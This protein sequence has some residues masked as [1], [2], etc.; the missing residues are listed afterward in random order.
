MDRLRGDGHDI[1]Y[2]AELAAGASDDTVL[3]RAN[4]EGALLVTADKDFGE[5]VHRQRRVSGGVLLVRLAGFAPERRAEIV[6]AFMRERGE[7]LVGSFTVITPGAAR[8]RRPP[9]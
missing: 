6:A 3:D 5:L 9:G 1:G 2:V 4:R 7:E 8:I